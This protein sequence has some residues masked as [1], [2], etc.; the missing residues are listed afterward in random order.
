ML[1]L[2]LDAVIEL[3]MDVVGWGIMLRAMDLRKQLPIAR[4]PGAPPPTEQEPKPRVVSDSQPI[5]PE[6]LSGPVRSRAKV[7]TKAIRDPKM[8]EVATR[9]VAEGWQLSATKSGHWRLDM[10]RAHI[11]FPKTPSDHRSWLNMRASA[12]RHGIDVSDV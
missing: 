9:A 7:A 11:I 8:R 4:D 5:V 2:A 10:G 6:Y 3:P 1:A 12:K